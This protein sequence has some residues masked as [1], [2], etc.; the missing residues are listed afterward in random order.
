MDVKLK[1]VVQDT[2]RHGNVRIYFRRNGK[3]VRLRGPVE[4][5]EFL[6]D[7]QAALLGLLPKRSQTNENVDAPKGTLRSLIE[8]YYRS[9]KYLAL[10]PRTRHVRRQILDRFCQ[11]NNDGQKPFASLEP[12]HLMARRDAMMDRP[13]AANSMIKALRQVFEVAIE[14]RLHDRNPAALVK[15]VENPSEGHMPWEMEDIE[16]FERTHPVGS[17]A[18]L[19]MSLALYTGQRKGD[20][21]ALG[22]ANI[23]VQE[24]HEGLAFI[25]QKN[26]R[27][28]PVHLW[29]PIVPAL[30]RVLDA[31]AT[32]ET[33]FIES[34][35][36]RP[37]TDGG[38]GNRFRKWCDEAGLKGL[39]IHGLRKTAAA[40]LAENGCTEQEI[41]AITGH[42][43]SKEVVRYTR[44]AQQKRRAANAMAKI[45][46]RSKA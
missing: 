44:N 8:H 18:R 6:A 32:G 36:H 34:E 1:Y 5:P 23:Q 40:V 37:F 33:T 19:A 12:Q 41:M 30:R 24:G 16:A 14:Y 28:K 9:S 7:Y 29:V 27:K 17:M 3:K 45:D 20:L 39:S 13:E 46:G 21:I 15:Y 10:A 31:T 26:G 11:N 25:Q 42:R 22:P 2:D 35:F 38:F 43:T 4:S